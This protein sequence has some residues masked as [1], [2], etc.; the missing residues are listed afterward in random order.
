MSVAYTV[1][2]FDFV[3]CASVRG[4]SFVL[5]FALHTRSLS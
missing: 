4:L 3:R 5:L 2:L 1:A